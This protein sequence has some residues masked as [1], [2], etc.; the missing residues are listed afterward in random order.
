MRHGH[1]PEYQDKPTGVLSEERLSGDLGP[2]WMWFHEL[3]LGHGATCLCWE[4]HKEPPGKSPSECSVG[5]RPPWQRHSF[6][7]SWPGMTLLFLGHR[8]AFYLI[9]K[10]TVPPRAE[11]ILWWVGFWS[12]HPAKVGLGH[13]YLPFDPLFLTI[14]DLFYTMTIIIMLKSFI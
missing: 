3:A 5:H 11:P 6:A 13:L 8:L 12:K 7:E 2:V 9:E 4:T 1:R 10:L 14:L